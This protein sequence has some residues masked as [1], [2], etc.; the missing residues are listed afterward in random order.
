MNINNKIKMKE[1]VNLMEPKYTVNESEGILTIILEGRLDAS[2]A[3]AL[4][5]ELRTFIG[6]TIL[7]INFIARDLDYIASAGL[8]TMIFSKQ[9][10][11]EQATISIIDAKQE[12]LDVIKMSGLDNFLNIK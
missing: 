6:N 12:V 9:K 1:G 11:G 5:D 2:N 4:M 7:E 10:I 3:P 8:R